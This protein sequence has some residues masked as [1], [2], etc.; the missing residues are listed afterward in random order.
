M[1]WTSVL[2]CAPRW[3]IK[4]AGTLERCWT[5]RIQNYGW[6]FLL[7]LSFASMVW[8][9]FLPLTVTVYYR[10]CDCIMAYIFTEMWKGYER[11]KYGRMEVR[12]SLLCHED[13]WGS[14][15]TAP[16]FLG[17]STRKGEWSTSSYPGHFM[18]GKKGPRTHWGGWVDPRASLN[19]AAMRK[20]LLLLGIEPC[21]P[22]L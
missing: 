10:G 8:A 20:I 17:L 12:L 7:L 14:G 18:P 9:I 19:M 22:S 21:F 5:Y 4:W 11:K 3:Y 13:I 1:F 16:F 6:N 15:G 2:A